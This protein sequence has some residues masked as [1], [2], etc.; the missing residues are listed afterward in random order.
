M[1]LAF[2]PPPPAA[3]ALP[4]PGVAGPAAACVPNPAGRRPAP[5][6]SA[7]PLALGRSARVRL[8]RAVTALL[9]HPGL[10]GASDAA[11]LA[12]VVLLSRT[13]AASGEASITTRELGRWLGLSVSTVASS[14][15]PDL[16]RRGVLD[17]DK[18]EGEYGQDTG[19][20]ARVVPLRDARGRVGDA[21]DLARLDFV[22]LLRLMEAL[23]APGW[24][25]RD[26]RV[27]PAGLLG[28]RTGRGAARARLALLQLVLAARESGEVRLCGGA[29]DRHAGRPATTV[30]R[31]LGTCSPRAAA[32]VLAGLEDAGLV[33]VSR[34]R[35]GS[36]LRHRSRI[37]VPAVAA[38]HAPEGGVVGVIGS[39]A[40]PPV[41]APPIQRP[42]DGASVQ[43]SGPAPREIAAVADP[44]VTADLHT[45]HTL[46]VD[47]VGDGAADRCF[48]G[49][50]RQGCCRR[51]ECACA[52][53]DAADTDGPATE[54]GDDEAGDGPLRGDKQEFI[55]HDD[56]QEQEQPETG[57]DRNADDRQER[58]ERPAGGVATDGP[59][60]TGTAAEGAST[61][62]W[63]A[64]SG[65]RAPGDIADLVDA[66]PG[67]WEA[68]ATPGRQRL[69][70][71]WIRTALRKID[72]GLIQFNGDWDQPDARVILAR[73]IARRCAQSAGGA[74]GARDVVGWLRGVVLPQRG[75]GE[76]GCDDGIDMNHGTPCQRC[77]DRVEDGRRMR[78]RAWTETVG[79]LR[80][81]TT[82]TPQQLAAYAQRLAELS[83]RE[84]AAQADD[85]R[86]L[87]ARHAREA[88]AWEAGRADREAARDAAAEREAARLAL[89]CADCGTAGA[90]GLCGTC[91]EDRRTEELLDTAMRAYT[92][93]SRLVDPGASP[94]DLARI[95]AATRQRME[96]DLAA[97]TDPLRAA[98][99]TG[100]ALATSRRLTAQRLGEEMQFA[101]VTS[102][103]ATDAVDEE[104]RRASYTATRRGH[105]S[106]LTPA[107]AARHRVAEVVLDRAMAAEPTAPGA[108]P[109]EEAWT[110]SADDCDSEP[111]TAAGLCGRHL[112]ARSGAARRT[113]AP[114]PAVAEDDLCADGCGRPALL[115][116]PYCRRCRTAH[117][118]EA[119]AAVAGGAR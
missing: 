64:T 9:S 86:D 10:D 92:A 30:S 103:A 7:S 2:A 70:A 29:V 34:R 72:S 67:L 53:E 13:S 102:V 49:A 15:L 51:P 112:V 87:A 74:T 101:M 32:A 118:Q 111:V 105:L 19:L 31:M 58:E 17:T 83:H 40:D 80:P 82:A 8:S 47:V 61:D 18:D 90:A 56:D 60:T 55:P 36:G 76:S 114:R 79:E 98:G 20:K 107:A 84:Q 93:A 63:R 115:V 23:A 113:A 27:T 54:P 66:A 110:C 5:T 45:D 88:A 65:G 69:A 100:P 94:E 33:V 77:G 57:E 73:R 75:C 48:S 117:V 37:T 14:V 1:S 85:A 41:T 16:R 96:D 6:R 50:G 104:S 46:L 43:V 59:V 4:R 81:G 28:S 116:G 22:L 78:Q 35:T 44:P 108:E 95:T 38:A 68:L 12:A 24:R 91:R 21:L 3:A 42:I 89:P 71:R 106:L 11:R 62:V 97:A 119:D 99:L 52:R 109:E 39:I 25:R 26:G